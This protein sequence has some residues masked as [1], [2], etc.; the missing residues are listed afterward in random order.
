[1]KGLSVNFIFETSA[2]PIQTKQVV[3]IPRVLS[4]AQ[5]ISLSGLADSH[6]PRWR[7]ADER[8][9]DFHNPRIPP[10]D[11]YNLICYNFSVFIAV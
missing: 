9:G 1:M 2:H 3:E 11:C 7:A 10:P 6:C 5:I 8:V 4:L